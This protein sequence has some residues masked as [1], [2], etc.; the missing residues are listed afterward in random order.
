MEKITGKI[1]NLTITKYESDFLLSA[2]V[3][4]QTKTKYK[5]RL[6]RADR[7]DLKKLIFAKEPL[8][9]MIENE[10][11]A[12]TNYCKADLEAGFLKPADMPEK[13][14]EKQKKRRSKNTK[15]KKTADSGAP[16][17]KRELLMYK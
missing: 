13:T 8:N 12:K 14:I 5:L 16:S 3:E 10:E 17:K 2:Q 4:S 15:A 11:N 1:F 6:G 7:Y 9:F